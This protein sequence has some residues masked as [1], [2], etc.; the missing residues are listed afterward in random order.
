LDRPADVIGTFQTSS[1]NDSETDY[2]MQRAIAG[3]LA[4][5]AGVFQDGRMIFFNV[6]RPHMMQSEFRFTRQGCGPRIDAFVRLS[7]TEAQE[8]SV[9]TRP[10]IGS[11]YEAVDAVTLGVRG[12]Y[13]SIDQ[14]PPLAVIVEAI[15]DHSGETSPLGF[16][17]CGE[18]AM[19]RLLGLPDRAPFP[20]HVLDEP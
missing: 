2:S 9:L 19:F 5:V 7:A 13:A 17:I 4:C 6:A 20:G 18:A 14:A 16:K 15:S 3:S 11:G 1:D 12:A 10:G 8:F